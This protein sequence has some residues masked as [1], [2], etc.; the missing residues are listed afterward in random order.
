MWCVAAIARLAVVSQGKTDPCEEV[1]N[2]GKTSAEL[3][4]V[5][6]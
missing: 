3:L 4:K 2:K 5:Q 1:S 6:R